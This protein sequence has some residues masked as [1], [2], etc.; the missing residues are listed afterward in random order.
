VTDAEH[1]AWLGT[2]T[3]EVVEF[4][5]G[6]R[7]RIMRD[8]SGQVVRIETWAPMGTEPETWAYYRFGK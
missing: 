8:P 5:E 2:L 4:E 6:V 1:L 3:S 7:G